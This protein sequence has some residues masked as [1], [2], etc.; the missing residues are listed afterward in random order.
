[1]GL[2]ELDRRQFDKARS[3]ILQAIEW[4]RKVLAAKPENP[5]HRQFLDDYL[6][7]LI[8]AARG[9]GRA[10]GPPQP[11]ASGTPCAIRIRASQPSMPGW[12]RSSAE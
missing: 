12:P 2:I 8:Q 3:D 11:A 5:E 9:L 7:V 1:M 6:T 10:D 4:Q